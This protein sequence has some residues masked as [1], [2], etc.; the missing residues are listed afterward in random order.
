MI[1]AAS[2]PSPAAANAVANTA[3]APTATETQLPVTSETSGPALGPA[4]QLGQDAFLKLLIVQI[5]MQDPLEPMSATEYVAQL[6]QF[7]V[8]EQLQTT[9]L[10][11]GILYQAQAVSQAVLLIGKHVETADGS[12]SGIVEAVLFSDGQ[13][14]L[15]V[16][17]EQINPGDVVQVW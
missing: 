1:T 6:A 12:V 7:S 13:P 16:G 3:A 2:P 4:A 17:D 10:H 15:I 5:Q 11:L 8:V 14:K 9:N